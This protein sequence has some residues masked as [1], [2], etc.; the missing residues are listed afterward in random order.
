MSRIASIAR[1]ARKAVV[2]NSPA[3]LTAMAVAGVVTTA[4][5]TGKATPRALQEISEAESEFTE[6]LT[7]NQKIYLTGHCFVPALTSGVLTIGCILMAQSINTRRQAA[8]ISAVT[9]AESR[10]SDY[11]AKVKEHLGDGKEQK[12]RDEVAQDQVNRIPENAQVIV[13]NEGTQLFLDGMSGR[14]FESSVERVRKAENK[15]NYKLNNE[16]YAS[17]NDFYDYLDLDPIGMG[18]DFGWRSEK[19]VDITFSTVLRNDRATIVID[20]ST[21][22]IRDY[23]KFG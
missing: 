12:I 15:L 17:L 21:H 22:P 18:E 7:L 3:I 4:Y 13:T 14:L 6:P 10:F 11:K 20:Y 9:L 23:Y 16:P 5:L 1:G 19:Q 8:M 2:D